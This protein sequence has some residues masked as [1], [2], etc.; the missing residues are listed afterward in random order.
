MAIP[1]DFANLGLWLKADALALSNGDPVASW[2][3]SSGNARHA[4]QGTGGK[5]PIFNTNVLNGL[6]A[7]TFDG[8]DD[9]LVSTDFEGTS[10]TVFVVMTVDADAGTGSA[11][12][13]IVAKPGQTLIRGTVSGGAAQVTCIATVNASFTVGNL[14]DAVWRRLYTYWDEAGPVELHNFVNGVELG[15]GA[16]GGSGPL[17]NS[18]NAW[19]IGSEINQRFH[20]GKIAEV[21]VY[22]RLLDASERAAV[23]QY[24]NDKYFAQSF[25]V[26]G[27]ASA[28]AFG[29]PQINQQVTP[30]AIVTAEAFGAP[31][32]VV[33]NVNITPTG[34]AS[35]EAVGVP[36]IHLVVAPAGI[37]S[38]EVFGTATTL[39][40]GVT[41]TP[42]GIVS[43]EAFGSPTLLPG[44]IIV[45]TSGI[46]S[47]EAFGTATVSSFIV[48]APGQITL[49]DRGTATAT[50]LDRAIASV[51]VSDLA[52]VTIRLTDEDL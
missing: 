32:L 22:T 51:Y 36:S 13:A 16:G 9:E 2:T 47:Q 50:V 12:R 5:Q 45:T 41:L 21:I 39:V 11:T 24:L 3:D 42:S 25:S 27:I 23:D 33:G 31:T 35:E 26:T 15:S 48:S 37:A 6:P 44:A 1:T 43:G 17:A 14:R 49:S 4:T 40:G 34:I 28:E 10:Q 38:A 46:A 19:H 18:A 20:K 8:T 7:I 52:S 30:G 29:T